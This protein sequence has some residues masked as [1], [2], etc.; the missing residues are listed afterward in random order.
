MP[1]ACSP[2]PRLLDALARVR[3]LS[4]DVD[5]VLTDGGLYYTESGE[6]LRRFNVRDGLGIQMLGAAGLPVAV[7]TAS[8]TPAIAQRCRRLNVGLVRTG[9]T[10]KLTEVTA[11]CAE[12]GITLAEVAHMGD[13]LNDLPLL[14]AVGCPITVA[15]GV[16]AVQEVALWATSRRGG[17]GAVREICDLLLARTGIAA[18]APAL[19]V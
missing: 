13:D 18:V 16:E 9:C 3:L 17:D 12:L 10:D 11:I 15:D 6:E 14:K 7:L 1:N 4:L 19:T 5:G 8:A 2:P